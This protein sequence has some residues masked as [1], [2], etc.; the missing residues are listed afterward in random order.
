MEAN[1]ASELRE[2]NEHAAKDSSLKPVAFAMS[3]LAVLV[4]IVTVLGHRAH[5]EAVLAQARA[6][7]T[8]NLYQAKKIRQNDTLLFADLLN[9]VPVKD[10]VATKKLLDSYQE[11]TNKWKADLDEEQEQATEFE[12]EVKLQE[13]RANRFDLGEALLEIGLV[14]TSI[15]LLTRQKGYAYLG[16]LLGIGGVVL[17]IVGFFL[18]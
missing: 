7:D 4:A 12:K 11:H 9:A 2:H 13:L 6:S 5:T 15:T 1:E 10:P 17:G 8:W 18:H 16:G 3:I 14:A